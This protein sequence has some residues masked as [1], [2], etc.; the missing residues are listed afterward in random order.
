M[1]TNP[2]QGRPLRYH[3]FRRDFHS[4]YICRGVHTAHQYIRWYVLSEEQLPIFLEWG[5]TT[6]KP[7][8]C[9]TTDPISASQVV[10]AQAQ[11][12]PSALE[13]RPT[14]AVG[15]HPPMPS[16]AV[17]PPQ[18]VPQDVQWYNINTTSPSSPNTDG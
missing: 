15:V 12:T 7:C 4:C 14:P 3:L 2:Q 17:V 10:E 1:A 9:D 18:P 13:I 11:I 6:T 16:P 5:T 8:T